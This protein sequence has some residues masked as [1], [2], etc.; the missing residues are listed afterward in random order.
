LN[1]EDERYV[2]VYTRKTVTMKLI[3][4]EGRATLMALLVE[5]DRAGVLDLDGE[6]PAEALTALSE[7]PIE[8]S[9]VGMARLIERGTVVIRGGQLVLPRFLE[10]QEARQSDAQRQRESRARRAATSGLPQSGVRAAASAGVDVTNRDHM[11]SQ[12]VTDCHTRS[13]A[14]TDGHSVLSSAVLSSAQPSRTDQEHPSGVGA[15]ARAPKPAKAA[16]WRRVPADWSP[17]ETDLAKAR[18][19]GV[20][21]ELELERFRDHEF[22][23]PKSDADATF[24]NWTRTAFERSSSSG[25]LRLA[26][27]P[28]D[29]IAETQRRQYER[30]QEAKAEEEALLGKAQ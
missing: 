27:R 25:Q 10:A 22:N 13:H 2:R 21:V 30:W 8:V 14:V 1:F 24:R 29:Q 20:N 11:R 4:W 6:G 17:S 3:G 9:R 16:R 7:L 15:R 26:P 5:V 12:N 28:G 19:L 18:A 23:T